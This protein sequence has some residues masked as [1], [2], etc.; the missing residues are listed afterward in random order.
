MVAPWFKF[1]ERRYGLDL[2]S[3]ALLRMGLALVMLGD[4][5]ARVHG[6]GY[7]MGHGGG[8]TA[9]LGNLWQSGYW[10][11]HGLAGSV[12]MP[13]AWQVVWQIVCYAIATCA[14][15]LMLV[16]YRTRWA[17]IIAWGMLV[18][19]HNHQPQLVY[20]TDEVLRTMLFWAM[21]LPWGSAYSVDQALNTSP[22]SPPKQILSGATLALMAQQFYI[23]AAPM[24][25]EVGAN[26]AGTTAVAIGSEI[27]L[28]GHH[29]NALGRILFNFPPS[30]FLFLYFLATVFFLGPFLLWSP[31]R[32]SRCRLMAVVGFIACHGTIALTLDLENTF[33]VLSC[34]TWLAFIPTLAWEGWRRRA[35]T[36]KQLGLKIYYDADCGFCKKVVHLLRTFLL[37]PGQV[38][39]Q[40][41]QSDPVI[42]TAMEAHNSWVIVDW[43]DGHHYKWHGIAYVVSLSPVLWPLARVLRWSPLMALGNRLYETIA[44][45]R[46]V[47]GN[48]TKP[49]KFRSFTVRPTGRLSLVSLTMLLVI[50]LWHLR[51]MTVYFDGV[52]QPPRAIMVLQRLTDGVQPLGPLVKAAGLDRS[53]VIYPPLPPQD[54]G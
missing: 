49:F 45:N 22:Q 2:R 3:L 30:L 24:I 16:G 52:D 33:H 34:I 42:Q 48:F 19:L 38:P 29:V 44:N 41:A 25:Y 5:W 32:A 35:F 4:L 12:G 46:Q 20:A 13:L 47:A 28:T 50:S 21:F 10:S 36:P 26:W 51:S 27:D 8:A 31:I 1:L 7:G 11:I 9:G 14:T 43:Q 53:W 15:L 39:L 6:S 17:T 54:K 40:T 37:L 18:S 23:Y